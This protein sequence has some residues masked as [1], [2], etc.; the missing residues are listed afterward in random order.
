MQNLV[1]K[2]RNAVG[3]KITISAEN[4]ED[5][6]EVLE[7]LNGVVR[8]KRCK[9]KQRSVEMQGKHRIVTYIDIKRPLQK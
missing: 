9:V 8:L 4:E 2:V 5:A 7:A 3:T 1:R 6:V